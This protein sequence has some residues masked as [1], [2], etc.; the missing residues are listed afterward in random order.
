MIIQVS[1]LPFYETKPTY[2][3]LTWFYTDSTFF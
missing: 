2:L 3:I 1:L